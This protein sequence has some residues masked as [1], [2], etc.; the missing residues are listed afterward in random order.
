MSVLCEMGIKATSQMFVDEPWLYDSKPKLFRSLTNLNKSCRLRGGWGVPWGK[1][2]VGD[3]FCKKQG[4]N[5]SYVPACA[6]FCCDE[7]SAT[8][9]T[10]KQSSFSLVRGHSSPPAASNR[11]SLENSAEGRKTNGKQDGMEVQTELKRMK[12]F[13]LFQL[14]SSTIAPEVSSWWSLSKAANNW[15]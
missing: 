15:C 11:L 4:S 9:A 10:L 2:H 8:L 7:G 3:I 12:M 6:L 1:D 14:V 13:S 5:D